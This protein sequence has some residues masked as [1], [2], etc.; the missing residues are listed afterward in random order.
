MSVKG[1]VTISL[2]EFL[3]DQIDEVDM[4]LHRVAEL[5]N[6][7][8]QDPFFYPSPCLVYLIFYYLYSKE[9]HLNAT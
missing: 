9:A 7:G 1:C 6:P 2:V 5:W 4:V 3:F 8:I